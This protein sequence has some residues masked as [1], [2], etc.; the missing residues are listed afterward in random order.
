MTASTSNQE[1]KHVIRE[2]KERIAALVKAFD[3]IAT[4]DD[5][6]KQSKKHMRS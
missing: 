2:M 6:Q 3:S 1:L 5:V 4:K